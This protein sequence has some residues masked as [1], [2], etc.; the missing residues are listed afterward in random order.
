MILLSTT[1]GQESIHTICGAEASLALPALGD[2]SLT[3]HG[4]LS[5]AEL[6]RGLFHARAGRIGGME[7]KPFQFSLS[8]MFA[9]LTLIA[10]ACAAI[11]SFQS[12]TPHQI[13]FGVCVFLVAVFGA[14]GGLVERFKGGL[15]VGVLIAAVFW[16]LFNF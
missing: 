6:T 9:E 8:W 1:T 3:G 10:I 15:L 12:I 11:P 14:L 2:T 4:Y 16:F 7:E 5:V 13:P